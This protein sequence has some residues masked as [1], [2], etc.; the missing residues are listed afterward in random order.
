MAAFARPT[1][2]VNSQKVDP[3]TQVDDQ[4][5]QEE[6]EKQLQLVYQQV[7]SEVQQLQGPC[8]SPSGFASTMP[9][10]M[11]SCGGEVHVQ[12]SRVFSV[13]QLRCMDFS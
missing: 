4:L 8:L 11:C 2:L 12:G 3:T 6:E 5:F 9:D 13:W 1:R 7:A 10:A